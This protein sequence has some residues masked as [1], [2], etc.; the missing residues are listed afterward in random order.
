MNVMIC[1]ESTYKSRDLVR[2]G[3]AMVYTNKQPVRIVVI[4]EREERPLTQ[5]VPFQKLF[6]YFA[7]VQLKYKGIDYKL[8]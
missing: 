5:L 4:Q 7:S 2:Y 1:D 8:I 6:A 3:F